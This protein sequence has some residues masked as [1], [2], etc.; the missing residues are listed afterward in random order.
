MLQTRRG[1]DAVIDA[2]VRANF[3]A[4]I[5]D[6]V[7]DRATARDSPPYG[8]EAE[9]SGDGAAAFVEGLRDAHG[10]DRHRGVGIR[11]ARRTTWRR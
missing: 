3:D 4:I 5:D 6:D 9:V 1:D 7:T 10:V 8:A 2:L 11:R